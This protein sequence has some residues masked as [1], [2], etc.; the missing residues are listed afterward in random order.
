MTGKLAV[1]SH[2]D[3][4][5]PPSVSDGK[6]T[7]ENVSDLVYHAR[8]YFANAKGGLTEELR[9]TRI[10]SCFHGS[11]V[12]DWA[13]SNFK[14]LAELD[15]PEFIATFRKRFLP[16][17]WENSV[18]KQIRSACLDPT[19]VRFETW[20][21]RLQKLNVTLRGTAS[22]LDEMQLRAQLAGGLDSELRQ[23]VTYD[24]AN[25]ITELVPWMHKL[26]TIDCK[27]QTDKKR[28]IEE[29]ETLLRANKHPNT[30][31]G[32][33]G[34]PSQHRTANKDNS[35][36][37]FPLRLTPEERKL[38]QDHEGC[39]KCRKFYAG[40]RLSEC[41][42]IL[43]SVGYKTL[44]AADAARALKAHQKANGITNSANMTSDATLQEDLVAA[45]FP[46]NLGL[47]DGDDFN[48]ASDQSIM[49]VSAPLK[50]EHLL[51]NCTLNG[52]K[53]SHT[54]TAL[55]DSGTHMVLMRPIIAAQLG[56]TPLPLTTPQS[57]NIALSQTTA[58]TAFT[59]YVELEPCTMNRKFQSNRLQAVLANNLSVPLILGMPF[60]VTNCVTCN[61]AKREC[62]VSVN[63][64]NY[65]ILSVVA[66]PAVKQT[67]ILATISEKARNPSLESSLTDLEEKYRKIYR[68]IFEPLPHTNKLPIEPVAR[69]QLKDPNIA[70]KTRNYAC[71]RKWREAWH[72]LLQQHLAAGRIRPSDAPAGSGAF[73]IPKADP[74]VLPRWVNDYR[75]LNAN[76]VPDSFPLPRIPEILADCG[77]GKY[78]AT[79]DMTNSFFQ[80][81]M[82]PDDV[83][84]TAVNTPWGLYEW[85]VM[86]MGIRNAPSIHQRRVTSALRPW[87]GRICH[88]YLDDIVIWSNTIDDH[89]ENVANVL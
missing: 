80:T 36:N 65:N 13:A 47:L 22:H 86:P 35:D 85:V 68:T 72:T 18:I 75:Q 6:I 14:A 52:P 32:S 50:C 17:D 25:D 21:H 19:K 10:L 57:V 4:S 61:Y 8:I 33:S 51:W 9:V 26:T 3:V 81:R 49:S 12:C 53:G 70:L 89:K 76:T 64:E 24:K 29:M 58:L 37:T 40:H 79:I 69:I 56:L 23:L 71:P 42:V 45:I 59:H 63:G 67:D 48:D 73:I 1:V 46:D 66:M 55:I 27:R 28:R 60:L 2:L 83:K 87:I 30:A 74:T 78:F 54:V 62:N 38:L 5:R 44:T 16:K 34:Q 15:F 77:T 20:A 82:H 88:I 84:L 31:Q 41:T 11:V 43:S 39:F 7:P